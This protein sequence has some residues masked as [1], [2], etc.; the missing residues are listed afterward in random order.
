MADKW[1]KVSKWELGAV[2]LG[3]L[4]GAVGMI[5]D[6]LQEGE[7]DL[8]HLFLRAFTGILIGM[9]IGGFLGRI[10]HPRQK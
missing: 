2:L 1:E 9:L 5:G 3:G 4:V 6:A 8:P 7:D 10:T